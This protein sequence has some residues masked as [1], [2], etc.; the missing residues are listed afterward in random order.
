MAYRI[1][2]CRE[3]IWATD[4]EA[5]HYKQMYVLWLKRYV[6]RLSIPLLQK[7]FQNIVY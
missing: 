6:T 3:V 2:V 1:E 7:Y 4:L 5:T